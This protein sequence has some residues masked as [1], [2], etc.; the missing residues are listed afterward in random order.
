[1]VYSEHAGLQNMSGG[2][3]ELIDFG[4]PAMEYFFDIQGKLKKTVGREYGSPAG[5]LQGC[6]L[7]LPSKEE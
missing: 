3:A 7:L 5:G 2:V 1:M 4:N 6:R